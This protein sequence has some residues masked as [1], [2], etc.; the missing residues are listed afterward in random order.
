[1]AGPVNPRILIVG[2]GRHGK[3]TTAE[4]LRDLYG[5][6]FVSSSEFVG[7]EIIFD[8]I[9]HE[10][11]YDF[12]AM[13]ADRFN[14]RAEWMQWIAA[15]NTPDETRTARTMFERGYDMYCGMRRREEL[16]AGKAAGLFDSIWWVDRSLHLPPEPAT[17]MTILPTDA[18][19][20]INNNRD[21][22][23]LQ[24]EIKEAYGDMKW[25]T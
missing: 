7:R 8:Q 9:G 5:M 14:R 11:D 20:F 4:M 15:Y 16:L 23:F 2:H 10:Y 6:K 24:D 17:S 13:F 1:M 21:L 3:D 22:A 25:N 19:M 12:D 18:D